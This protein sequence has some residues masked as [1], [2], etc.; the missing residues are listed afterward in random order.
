MCVNCVNKS[1]LEE[2][3]SAGVCC[4]CASPPSGRQGAR[5]PPAVLL[6]A[7]ALT[8]LQEAEALGLPLRSRLFSHFLAGFLAPATHEPVWELEGTAGSPQRR[9]AAH[10]G[11]QH[12]AK[13]VWNDGAGKKES[14]LPR[15]TMSSEQTGSLKT[16]FL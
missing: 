5:P 6:L 10:S 11:P 9:R 13:H 1:N 16:E 15:D 8:A 4:C 14:P 3:F 7:Q 12:G 2:Q